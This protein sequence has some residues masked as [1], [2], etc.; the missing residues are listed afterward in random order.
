MSAWERIE[1][2]F[3][4][5]RKS[6]APADVLKV[7]ARRWEANYRKNGERVQKFFKTA[8]AAKLHIEL[9]LR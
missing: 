2:G 7:G 8:S 4:R 5:Y 1:S 9:T 6:T 3:Y